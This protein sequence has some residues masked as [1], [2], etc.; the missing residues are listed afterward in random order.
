MSRM[1][2]AL[3][4]AVLLSACDLTQSPPAPTR[5]PGPPST[6]VPPMPAPPPIDPVVV[7][8]IGEDVRGIFRGAHLTYEFT[9]PADG[10]LSATLKWDDRPNG[11]VLTLGMGGQQGR[12]PLWSDG[13]WRVT[14]GETYRLVVGPGGTD[15]AYD[16]PFVLST[17]LES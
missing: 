10:W 17:R 11:S 13:K 5:L 1:A 2:L 16:D 15:W 3:G 8:V 14:G 7:M 9:A 6:N 12:P 4:A